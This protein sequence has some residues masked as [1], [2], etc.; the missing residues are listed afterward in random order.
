MHIHFE[1]QY[2]QGETFLHQADPRLK[3]LLTIVAILMIGLT[4]LERWPT[5]AGFLLLLWIAAQ[6]AGLPAWWFLK[7]SAVALPFVVAAFPLPF[8]VP[9]SVLLEL[10][11]VHW[12]VTQE[13]LFRMT[14]IILKSWISVQAA[15]L[16]AATT[17]FDKLLWGLRGLFL[18]RILVG[19]IGLMYRYL[20]VLAD[21]VLRL[22]R[23]R[24][25]RSGVSSGKKPPGILWQAQAT[26]HLAGAL[27]VRS[28]ERSERVYLAMASRG[29]RGEPRLLEAVRWR[30]ADSLILLAAAGLYLGCLAAGFA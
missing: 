8:T 11:G 6:R 1:D 26:G 5:F 18:P 12:P 23:A 13:G 25:A 17:R 2:H 15:V 22:M 27:F 30:R 19:V 24:A 29:Y 3:I 16:L 28:L 4:P 7:R 20:F 21:E 14:G 10:P 9:G